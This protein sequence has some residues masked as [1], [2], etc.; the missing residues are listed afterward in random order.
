KVGDQLA[1]YHRQGRAVQFQGV[2]LGM[3]ESPA[4]FLKIKRILPRFAVAELVAKKGVVQ[5][6]DSVKAW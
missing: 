1:V 2:D 5:V 3:D 6:G 4:A